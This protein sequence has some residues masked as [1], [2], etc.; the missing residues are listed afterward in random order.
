MAIRLT[1]Q[2][3]EWICHRGGRVTVRLSPRHGC[4]GGG[5][6]VAVAE[7]AAPANPAAFVHEE[8][9]GVSVALDP[10]LAGEDLLIDVEGMLGLKRLFVEGSS[11]KRL[12][13]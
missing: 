4:C 12:R 11:P 8:C 7:A 9:E 2:A 13:E 3:R 6:R 5:A 1:E 10:D